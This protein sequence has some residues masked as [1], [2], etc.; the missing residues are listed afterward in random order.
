[1][2]GTHH[3]DA[4]RAAAG[5]HVPQQDLEVFPLIPGAEGGG[6]EGDLVDHDQDDVHA[7][8]SGDLPQPPLL[9]GRGP[10]PDLGLQPAQHCDG[11][12]QV[13][14]DEDV[15]DLFPHTQFDFL[16]VEQDEPD[17][18]AE[19]GVGEDVLDQDGLA[20]AGFA[21]DEQV[22]ADQGQVDGVAVLVDAQVDRIVDGQAGHR[23]T[24]PSRVSRD[25]PSR[26]RAR[27]WRSTRHT[28]LRRQGRLANRWR[29]EVR[30]S[31]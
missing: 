9:E 30:A 17:V 19:G 15:G 31:H 13:G 4:D 12:G 1:L 14:S 10:P 18:A 7:V 5:D 29:E 26:C 27:G 22:A 3:G 16:A 28:D 24:P 23:N 21:A 2:G 11:V 6:V 20:G 8:L 25:T